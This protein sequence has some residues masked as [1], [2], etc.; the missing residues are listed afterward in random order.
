MQNIKKIVLI[1]LIA[2][3]SLTTASFAIEEVGG[4]NGVNDGVNNE[5]TQ[6]VNKEG[7]QTKIYWNE[8]CYDRSG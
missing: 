2:C 7:W 1:V 8:V 3:F 5:V 6:N 4:V